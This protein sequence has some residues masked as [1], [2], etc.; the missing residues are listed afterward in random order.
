MKNENKILYQDN[1]IA[2]LELTQGQQTIIDID[3]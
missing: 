2:I 3:I 1:E